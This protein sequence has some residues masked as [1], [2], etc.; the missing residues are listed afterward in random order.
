MEA[1]V[2]ILPRDR[3]ESSDDDFYNT[4]T[5]AWRTRFHRLLIQT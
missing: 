1:A 5:I 4:T 2:D 3:N